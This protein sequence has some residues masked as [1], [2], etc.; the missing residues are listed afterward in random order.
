MAETRTSRFGLVQWGVGTDSPSRVDFNE[1]F[2]NLENRAAYDDGVSAASLPV[3]NV[4]AGRYALVAPAG[5]N[6]TLY[7]RSD[8]GTWDYAGGNTSPETFYVRP[9][10]GVGAG[11][12]ARSS[13]A[14]VLSHPDGSGGA[15]AT[16]AYDGSAALGGTLR[17]YDLN[18]TAA[19]NVVIGATTTAD[20]ATTGRLLVRTR[21][22]GER[23]LVLR[24]HGSGA[25]AMLAVQTSAGSD[26]LTLNATGQM[27]QRA[28]A[29]FGGASVA[30]DS[31]LAVAPSTNSGDG[32]INGLVLHGQAA[33][34]DTKTILRV[35]RQADDSAALMQLGRDGF[36]IGRLPWGSTSANGVVALSGRQINFRATAYSGDSTMW[37][38][39]RADINDPANASLDETVSTLSR[40]SG[41]FRV[42]TSISQALSTGGVN[43]TLKRY[44]DLTQRFLELHRMGAGESIE[45]VGAWDSEGRALNGARWI[46]AGT[47]RDS[48]QQLRHVS[49]KRYATPGVNDYQTGPKIET[50]GG[51]ATFTYT[52]GTMQSRSG[53]VFD[54]NI[55]VESE[56]CIEK[57]TDDYGSACFYDVYASVN[58][59][60]F[61]LLETREF[62]AATVSV[63]QRPVGQ[64]P[65]VITTLGQVP[66]DA[67][68]Q[69]RIRIR[70]GANAGGPP[71]YLRML[72]INVEES[73]ISA[74]SA[75]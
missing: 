57:E 8:G 5:P 27:Q 32:F 56:Y 15:G 2:L 58:G 39:V 74:Y 24:A 43:L 20:P 30:T 14:L 52:F 63:G 18:D 60:A 35:L 45:V 68:F 70:N 51:A 61:T 22:D 75:P 73:L 54:M 69:I 34:A 11:G 59:G 41:L 28:A 47:M 65:H 49:T 42:P 19:G 67:T 55:T 4:V 72:Y 3:T 29:A 1:A 46:S 16:L 25:G 17:V 31:I 6:K 40:T 66:A 21:T 38:L 13:A 48:R 71:I 10:V 7:R 62:W 37:R 53:S 36:T 50:T 64:T 9:Y 23:G 12:P 44:T 26:V 33:P